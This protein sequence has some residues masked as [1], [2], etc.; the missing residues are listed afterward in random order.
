MALRHPGVEP[1][2]TLFFSTADQEGG[3]RVEPGM[4]MAGERW[5]P[6]PTRTFF[7]FFIFFAVP[8]SRCGF[9]GHSRPSTKWEDGPG[10]FP[11]CAWV[12]H[13][14]PCP[15]TGLGRAGHGPPAQPRAS[16]ERNGKIDK[17]E[18]SGALFRPSGGVS[19][20]SLRL[21]RRA[22]CRT[23]ESGHCPWRGISIFTFSKS[24]GPV[25]GST[26]RARIRFAILHFRNHVNRKCDNRIH[27][28]SIS[29]APAVRR[30][31]GSRLKAGMTAP[32]QGRD[33]GS[34]LG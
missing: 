24:S 23:R 9:R 16:S 11:C 34:G 26:E 2:S 33:D 32:G 27:S 8:L 6:V 25:L 13:R 20:L 10:G 3:C 14:L 19:S 18:G 30:T 28:A 12:M 31:G 21:N 5:A 15:R 4:T 17:V 22:P 1:G 29:R 7:I